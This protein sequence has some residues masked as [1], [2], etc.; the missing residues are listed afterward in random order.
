MDELRAVTEDAGVLLLE[1]AAQ[2]HGA[3]YRGRPVG[4]LGHAAMFSFTPTKNI[5]TGEGGIVTTADAE[6]AERLRLL[7]NHGQTS[8]YVHATL[9]WNWRLSEMQAAMGVVQLGKLDGI[10]ARKRS[11]AEWMAKRLAGLS[12]VTTPFAPS[13]REHPYMLYTLLIDTGRDAVM[14]A[15]HE[16]GIEA[17]LYFPPAHTQPVFGFPPR[18]LPVT[19]H[20]SRHMLSVPFH[21]RLSLEGEEMRENRDS[22]MRSQG[23]PR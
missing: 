7:R 14:A 8:K 15:L 13:D 21:A 3:T 11:N 2:A 16:A 4:G 5:T 9:G 20:L 18:S 22:S 23:C 1:D 19:E 10:L 17:K 6:L 12:G